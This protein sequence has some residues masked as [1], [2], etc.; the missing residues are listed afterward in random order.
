MNPAPYLPAVE[1]AYHV[2]ALNGLTEGLAL[3]A[4]LLLW[5]FIDWTWRTR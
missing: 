1:R 3:L 2:A 5:A 4:G